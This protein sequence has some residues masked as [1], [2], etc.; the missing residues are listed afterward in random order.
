MQ[1]RISNKP[2]NEPVKPEVKT[3]AAGKHLV[4]KLDE[5]TASDTQL[6]DQLSGKDPARYVQIMNG[7]YSD[8]PMPKNYPKPVEI[9]K[10][11]KMSATKSWQIIKS[12]MN[13][14]ELEEW[15]KD[16]PED[17]PLKITPYKLD[18]G[19]TE[20]LGDDEWWLR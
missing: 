2:T 15:Y 8:Q 14:D 19:L 17:R 16:H 5:S 11:P 4:K 12:S 18:E 13:K 20:M 9:K 10:S 3:Q 6:Y 1:K 7:R